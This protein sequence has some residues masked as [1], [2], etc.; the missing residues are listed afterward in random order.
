MSAIHVPTKALVGALL[1]GVATLAVA[2]MV[3]HSARNHHGIARGP[4]V[5]GL[6]PRNDEASSL[7]G[8]AAPVAAAK[9]DDALGKPF[10]AHVVGEV[11]PSAGNKGGLGGGG[12]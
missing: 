5:G 4:Y 9:R 11:E 10:S 12:R 1:L 6:L 2:K 7:P 8:T 3:H